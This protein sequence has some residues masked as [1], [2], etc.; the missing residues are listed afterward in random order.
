MKT[1]YHATKL[2]N[3]DAILEKGLLRNKIENAIFL[4]EKPEHAARF[5]VVQ[6][7][8]QFVII[9]VKVHER[10]LEESF[11]HSEEFFKCKAWTYSKDIAPRY[12]EADDILKYDAT[13]K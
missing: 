8:S 2:E 11:D 1:M 5:L 9:P 13:T 12:I 10:F 4:C 3:L 7:L 6:G